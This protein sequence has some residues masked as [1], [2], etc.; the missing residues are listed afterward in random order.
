MHELV[1]LIEHLNL[2]VSLGPLKD[3]HPNPS[4]ETV[5]DSCGSGVR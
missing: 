2:L 4:S 5:H 1:P 3:P